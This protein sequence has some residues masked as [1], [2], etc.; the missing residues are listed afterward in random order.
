MYKLKGKVPKIHASVYV[1]PG[2]Q[3]IGDVELD[4]DVTV[5]FNAVLRGDDEPIK[6]GKGSNIQDGTVVH[7]DPGF[8]V[9]VG[10]NVTIGHNVTLHGCTVGDGATIGMGATV[11]SGAVI[12]EGALVAAGALV[13][14]GKVI[15]PGMLAAGVPVKV[16]R[17][18]SPE[19]RDRLQKGVQTYIQKGKRFA[20]ELKPSS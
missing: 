12:G 10:K 11:L 2:A 14:E 9:T 13:P 5:W 20:E 18:V 7:I 15:E 1:A 3:I 19:I 16:I 4:E 17:Q 8:P 6:I